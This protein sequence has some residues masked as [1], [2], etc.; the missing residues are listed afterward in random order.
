MIPGQMTRAFLKDVDSG[1][2]R[3]LSRAER[4][5]GPE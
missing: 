5:A 4:F 3:T 1:M 2:P